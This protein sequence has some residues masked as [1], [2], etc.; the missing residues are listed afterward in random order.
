MKKISYILFAF[1]VLI[2]IAS[3][4]KKP[5][6]VN[7][8]AA[9]SKLKSTL[10]QAPQKPAVPSTP[11]IP[12]NPAQ[13]V[14]QSVPTPPSTPKRPDSSTLNKGRPSAKV[15]E[16][17]G[18]FA[19]ALSSSDYDDN[20][21]TNK[22]YAQDNYDGYY[23]EGQDNSG[24]N[25]IPD[26]VPEKEADVP[27]FNEGDIFFYQ[28]ISNDKPNNEK[29]RVVDAQM[30]YSIDFE[31]S[32]TLYEILNLYD[33]NDSASK[34]ANEPK[35]VIPTFEGLKKELA[36]KSKNDQNFIRVDD[37]VN[38]YKTDY[39]R[40]R[41]RE[42]L[43]SD[44]N[45]YD[46]VITNEAKATTSTKRS[47]GMM[48]LDTFISSVNRVQLKNE[49]EAI[50][51]GATVYTAAP[52]DFSI[53]L[54][55][56]SISYLKDLSLGEW[57]LSKYSLSTQGRVHY[58]FKNDLDFMISGG[59]KFGLHQSFKSFVYNL[60]FFAEVGIGIK[61]FDIYAG[62]GMM[63][64]DPNYGFFSLAGE[65]EGFYNFFFGKHSSAFVGANISLGIAMGNLVSGKKI[66]VS[67]FFISPVAG[68]KYS[69][70]SVRND[71][72]ISFDDRGW[73]DIVILDPKGHVKQIKTEEVDDKSRFFVEVHYSGSP[74]DV[75]GVGSLYSASAFI[76]KESTP[77]FEL[78]TYA[79][80]V[81]AAGHYKLITQPDKSVGIGLRLDF[82]QSFGKTYSLVPLLIDA[83]L[84]LLNWGVDLHAGIGGSFTHAANDGGISLA[85]KAGVSYN[86]PITWQS[87]IVLGLD[88]S[89][90][91]KVDLALP[92][93]VAVTHA[94]IDP[95]IG[96][97]Y[98]F[99]KYQRLVF[100]SV[101]G[102][103]TDECYIIDIV[104]DVDKKKEAI[105]KE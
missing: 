43:L 24:F 20:Y 5:K 82:T 3:C 47:L 9:A 61:N 23:T 6:G 83:N 12:T 48:T 98:S 28:T 35:E 57:R 72:V 89:I 96:Y 18:E 14:K 87:F 66:E 8:A 38:S 17:S 81:A 102:L 40:Q 65:V 54:S 77:P 34:K 42:A 73:Y 69:L 39:E 62:V 19:P 26:Y 101:T 32:Y 104:N 27:Y 92:E 51:L 103:A 75:S 84:S 33:D 58:K 78:S 97:K 52:F 13:A 56:F 70:D 36:E 71:A 50:L 25:M 94:Q 2:A 46:I 68:Y 44:S 21:N 30:N 88:L 85:A 60:P 55:P 79:F 37:K 86:L 59:L 4:S 11:S 76:K 95:V 41:R 67:K 15:F 10:P 31:K 1:A 99:D 64:S 53:S 45:F 7:P 16:G 100:D 90:R 63:L 22:S 91:F 93:K 49:E 80:N 74:F 29:Y 105:L